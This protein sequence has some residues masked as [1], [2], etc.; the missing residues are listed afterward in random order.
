MSLF[1]ATWQ[2]LWLAPLMESWQVEKVDKSAAGHVWQSNRCLCNFRLSRRPGIL[3]PAVAVVLL[4]LL[5]LLRSTTSSSSS[6]E[7][8]APHLA[9][10]SVAVQWI[11]CGKP[12]SRKVIIRERE[13][14]HVVLKA[15]NWSDSKTTS[16]L[17][18]L[19][20][21]PFVKCKNV[22]HFL[23]KLKNYEI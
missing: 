11:Q 23:L 8:S 10:N 15:E 13:W 2:M 17:S 3:S 22:Q 16:K 14:R 7:Y 1:V 12:W 19:S 20:I 5:L 4:P 9:W 18:K 6:L 21:F